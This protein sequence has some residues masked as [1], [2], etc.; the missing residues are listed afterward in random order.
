MGR[1]WNVAAQLT[2]FYRARYTLKRAIALKILNE[3]SRTGEIKV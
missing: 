1:R 2:G 3:A